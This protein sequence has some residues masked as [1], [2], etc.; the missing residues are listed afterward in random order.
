MPETQADSSA[1]VRQQSVR[2]FKKSV[3]L[4]AAHR[5]LERD[6]IDGATVRAIA[7]EAGYTPGALYA[8]YPNKDDILADLLCR[9]L[10]QAARTVRHHVEA[11]GPHNPHP[12]ELATAFGAYYRQETG[13]FDLLLTV[14]QSQRVR[15]LSPDIARTLNGRLIAALSP[16]A[17]ALETTGRWER[18]PASE[19]TM[20]AAAL[21][22]GILV[23]ENS[24]RLSALGMDGPSLIGGGYAT[25]LT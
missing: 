7:K 4:D 1:E 16:I 15:N 23:L 18:Q 24:G 17:D 2:T 8:Y 9:S 20:Q 22:L 25:L 3:I 11:K 21:A 13:E 6:G 12:I 10:G 5:V 19:A 14:L